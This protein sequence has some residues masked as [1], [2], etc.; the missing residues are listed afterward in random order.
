LVQA[1]YVALVGMIIVFACLGAVLLVMIA[2]G[3][4]FRAKE[5]ETRES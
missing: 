3:K 1:L 5:S 4:L 2:I